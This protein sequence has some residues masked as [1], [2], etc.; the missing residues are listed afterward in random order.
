MHA[1]RRESKVTTFAMYSRI[2]PDIE[3][4]P[5]AVREVKDRMMTRTTIPR[6]KR[7]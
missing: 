6:V 3:T 1:I 4:V 2:P 5:A 7:G